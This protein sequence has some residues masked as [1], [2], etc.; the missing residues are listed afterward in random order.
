MLP[1]ARL[2]FWIPP[3]KTAVLARAGAA[4][5]LPWLRSRGRLGWRQGPWHTLSVHD[6]LPSSM[7]TVLHQ[8]RQRRLWGG[9]YGKGVGYCDGSYIHAF[10]PGE[11]MPSDTVWAM[12]EDR[13]ATNL[14]FGTDQGG[15]CR[16]DGTVLETFD[17][18][19]GLGDD[20]VR[21]VLADRRDR[22]WTWGWNHAGGSPLSVI[23][24]GQARLFR[25]PDGRPIGRATVLLEDGA[26]RLWI[27][28]DGD[29]LHCC[30]DDQVRTF[31]CAQ[32]LADDN[33]RCIGEDRDG[34][35][36]FGTYG[37]GVSRF[38]GQV[39]QT[40]SRQDGLVNDAVQAVLEDHSGAIWIA[41]EA[42]VTHYRPRS[43]PP[44]VHLRDVV[45]HQRHGPVTDLRV[46][47][48]P[49][50]VFFEYQ[51]SSLLTR[52]NQ[53]AYVYRL[54]GR[55]DAW[56]TTCHR[57]VEYKDLPAG[58]YT[59]QVRAVD[60]DLDYSDPLAVR[61]SVEPDLRQDR[62]DALASELSQA[63]GLQH[64]IGQSAALKA[65]LQ[66]IHTVSGRTRPDRLPSPQGDHDAPEPHR[67]GLR[68]ATVQPGRRRRNEM[69]SKTGR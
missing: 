31:T 5:V 25:L 2:S 1:V 7:T 26:G 68:P 22:L 4:T 17:E 3:D 19:D 42:G 52:P 55:D 37:G 20:P 34:Q 67:P 18:A 21:A 16:Y 27:G 10:G 57:R 64:F 48:P 66:Q 11:G 24:N 33:V 23:E 58:T 60:R 32:G 36:L 54:L 14:W 15:I 29:G 59:F 69:G 65:V 13:Q 6:R 61:L 43:T 35:L 53:F 56:R 46:T 40:L 49:T 51:G 30:H 45:A 39:F 12:A 62:I 8:D 50:L 41:T 47:S 38:D 28:T 9:T 44:A 63:Q